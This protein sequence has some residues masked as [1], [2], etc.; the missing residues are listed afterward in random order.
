M[1]GAARLVRRACRPGERTLM[2]WAQFIVVAAVI[3]FAGANLSKYGD[4]IAE[5][6]GMGRT[7]VGVVLIA[8][9]TSL[10][11][12]ITGA[13]SVVLFDV[14]DLAVGNVLG[15]CMFNVLTI[16]LLDVLSGPTPISTRAHQGQV[17][18]AAFGVLLLG[19]V[20][21]SLAA[22][23]VLPAVG[24]IGSYSLIFLLIYMIAPRTVFLFERRRIAELVH[25]R[26]EAS[27][28]EAITLRK[29]YGSYALNAML[30]IGAAAYLPSLGER[31][32][33]VTGLGGTFVRTTFIALATT[34]PELVVSISALRIDAADLVFGNL[35][36]SNLFNLAVL[37][38]D[39][40]LYF[41]GPLFSEVAQS[42][43]VSASAAMSM[44]A[45]A[46][47]GLTYRVSK[48]RLPIA[49]DSLAI[50]S[51]TDLALGRFCS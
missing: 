28:Y 16:A 4:V 50:L 21:L 24:W 1:A 27:R 17:L 39:D 14:P 41:N 49:W 29:A 10:P 22:R 42:H 31:I 51:V 9:V 33:E 7:W 47:I 45:I 11:E 19:M 46:V 32:A 20:S 25:D 43:V 5:K 34:L 8:S 15:A 44:T 36:G 30:V 13:S 37:A 12:L 18:A 40:L 38:I 23:S 3:L 26:A 48:K 6:T 35:L 2:L